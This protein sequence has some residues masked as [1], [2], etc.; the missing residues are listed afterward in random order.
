MPQH[1][2]ESTGPGEDEIAFTSMNY[3]QDTEAMS[4]PA[5]F[6]SGSDTPHAARQ[7]D[8]PPPSPPPTPGTSVVMPSISVDSDGSSPT[9]PTTPSNGS[10]PT[11]PTTPSDDGPPAPQTKL[12]TSSD[13]D[14]SYVESHNDGSDRVLNIWDYVDSEYL[15]Y[16]DNYNSEGSASDDEN[17]SSFDDGGYASDSS[18]ASNDGGYESDGSCASNDSYIT[19]SC[20]SSRRASRGP[21][22]IMHLHSQVAVPASHSRLENL[23]PE[24]R[25]QILSSMPDLETLRSMV[26]ASPAMHAV[27]SNNDH[28][29]LAT[30]LERD[31][32]GFYVDA[33]ANSK[34]R[35]GELK[36]TYKRKTITS[37]L[38]SYN[39]WLKAPSS[40]PAA[41]SLSPSRVR[42]MAAYHMS[43][44]RPLARQYGSWALKNLRQV[45]G[46]KVDTAD[47]FQGDTLSQNEEIR[48]FQA[49]YRF[50]TYHHIFRPYGPVYANSQYIN[51]N[52]FGLF[53]P[54]E[55]EAI[56]CVSTFVAQYWEDLFNR[57]QDDMEPDGFRSRNG[58][59]NPGIEIN[60]GTERSKHVECMI[61]RGLKML[62]RITRINN[63][64]TLLR[65]L[66]KSLTCIGRGHEHRIL[67]SMDG[68]YNELRR[69]ES[70][71]F[72]GNLGARDEAQQR[73]D[74][75]QFSGDSLP[76][77]GPPLAWVLL[78]GG[79]Y[80]HVYGNLVPE[81]LKRWG[82]VMWDARRWTET[83]S[84]GLIA[85]EWTGWSSK[86]DE[87]DMRRFS[88]WTPPDVW[89]R[90]V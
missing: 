13:R 27:Y 9:P 28:R 86:I 90:G 55:A 69:Y 32:E 70:P 73:Q 74:P 7:G 71:N 59:W 37:F 19:K 1:S 45:V 53:D 12:S 44:A 78:W 14:S 36:I 56:G 23:P 15:S 2:P 18:C 26:R 20:P 61:S 54:W 11:P 38:N 35:G 51:E 84:E 57:V 16:L 24:L 72:P 8:N 40:V 21:G 17:D 60:L 83:A 66:D 49:L 85:K 75:M 29:I 42:W 81:S 62:A 67:E 46:P 50:E 47:D 30:C 5:L 79:K 39:G 80:V 25:I 65:K 34:S 87:S 88:G 4:E 58:Y 41:K 82:Y 77:N 6:S 22:R 63:D 31:L 89:W 52:F 48:I 10:F 68:G 43:V 33:Y 76:P 3:D 64:D